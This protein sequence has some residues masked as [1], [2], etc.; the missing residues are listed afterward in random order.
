MDFPLGS[1]S[2]EPN[3]VLVCDSNT[4][5]I[6]LTATAATIPARMSTAS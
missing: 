2:L 1:I 5:S 3:L 4:G 6:T